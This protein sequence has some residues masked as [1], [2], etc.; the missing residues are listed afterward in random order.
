MLFEDVRTLSF[1]RSVGRLGSVL[2]THSTDPRVAD[3]ARCCGIVK[4]TLLARSSVWCG[5]L[6]L[7][8]VARPTQYFMHSDERAC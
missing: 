2:V 5:T 3:I 6:K 7:L 8:Q 1:I 4:G